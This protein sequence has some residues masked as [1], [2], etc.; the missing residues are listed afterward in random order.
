MDNCPIC[1][2]KIGEK[3]VQSSFAPSLCWLETSRNKSGYI[4][5]KFGYGDDFE[6][7][8]Y[9]PRYCPECGK[10]NEQVT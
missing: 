2:L 7:I 4:I 9:S 10:K 6:H 5:M 8:F 3:I 1:K